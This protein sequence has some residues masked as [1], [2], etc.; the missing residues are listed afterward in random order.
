MAAACADKPSFLN[1]LRPALAR[2]PLVEGW[3]TLLTEAAA[4]LEC[5]GL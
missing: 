4:P 2:I 3:L 5:S 1:G